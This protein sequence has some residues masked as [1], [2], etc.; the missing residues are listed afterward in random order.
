MPRFIRDFSYLANR[1]FNIGKKIWIKISLKI[2]LDTY[3][4]SN[5]SNQT[6]KAIL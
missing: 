6:I 2:I 5:N 3:Y 1:C 4:S